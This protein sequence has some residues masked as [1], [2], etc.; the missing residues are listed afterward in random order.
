ML[1]V[2][3]R[4]EGTPAAL[5]GN[6]DNPMPVPEQ[7]DSAYHTVK[8]TCSLISISTSRDFSQVRMFSKTSVP[9]NF[10]L[11]QKIRHNC[12]VHQKST[13]QKRKTYIYPHNESLVSSQK[14][15]HDCVQADIE[16]V[17]GCA[18]CYKGESLQKPLPLAGKN[19]RMSVVPS[20]LECHI[21]GRTQ[22]MHWQQ[23]GRGTSLSGSTHLYYAPPCGTVALHHHHRCRCHHHHLHYLK[24]T[25]K[26]T[27][28]GH[29]VSLT[30]LHSCQILPTL[31]S[32]ATHS[33]LLHRHPWDS[34]VPGV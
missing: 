10:S 5:P 30:H 8:L 29:G 14:E 13:D 22:S 17:T 12:L 23:T 32:V 25:N 21:S 19:S 16:R 6:H 20:S 15:Q 1:Y 11:Q 24:E 7:Y 2:T 27:C 28:F 9:P 33:A 18:Q 34:T 4:G 31:P 3:P 26:Q